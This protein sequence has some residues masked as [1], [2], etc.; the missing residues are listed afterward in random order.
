MNT[1]EIIKGERLQQL[2]D[3]YLGTPDVFTYNPLIHMEKHKHLNIASIITEYNNPPVVFCYGHCIRLLYEKLSFFMNK[4]VLITHNSDE[5]IIESY[6][7][8]YILTHPLIKKWFAQNVCFHHPKLYVLPIGLANNH[9]PHG[10][11]SFF[12]NVDIADYTTIKTEY[13]YFCFNQS[14]NIQKRSE[15][16]NKLCNKIPSVGWNTPTEYH[17]M[18]SK[19]RFCICPEGNGVDTHRLWEA[20]YLK[21]VPVVIRSPFIDVLQKQLPNLPL[22]VLD[23][24]DDFS[25]SNLHYDHSKMGSPDYYNTL[26]LSYYKQLIF[27]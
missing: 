7:H 24:W 17:N 4:F 14:T 15:C 21:C 23:S 1:D 2:A 3:V 9:W 5:N 25:V 11:L 12:K 6:H 10:D 26:T 8:L 13:T 20:L 18:L 22:I 19:Y 27:A 16:Y